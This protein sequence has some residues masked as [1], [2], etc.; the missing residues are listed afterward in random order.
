MPVFP[1][2]GAIPLPRTTL[3]LNVFEPRYLEMIDDVMP[4]SRLLC[5]VQA[6]GGSEE[7]ELPAASTV[8]LPTYRRLHRPVSLPGDRRRPAVWSRSRDRPLSG[9]RRGGGRHALPPVD[10]GFERFGE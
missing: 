6:M 9:H 7:E 5:T 3:P 1:L 8:G 2:R 10:H 4:G